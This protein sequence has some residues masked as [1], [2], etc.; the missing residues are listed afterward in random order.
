MHHFIEHMFGHTRKFLTNI[1]KFTPMFLKLSQKHPVKSYNTSFNSHIQNHTNLPLISTQNSLITS[2][3]TQPI[4][5]QHTH[6]NISHNYPYITPQTFKTSYKKSS[7]IISFLKP[8]TT[9]ICYFKIILRASL[10]ILS[11]GSYTSCITIILT[12][13]PLKSILPHHSIIYTYSK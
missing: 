11:T 3:T 8:T 4:S 9:K 2:Q 13:I 12:E 5:N 10:K 7:Q 6:N 1:S